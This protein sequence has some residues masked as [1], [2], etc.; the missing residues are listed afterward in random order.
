MPAPAGRYRLS[1]DTRR[2]AAI[3]RRVPLFAVEQ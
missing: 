3:I 1:N 2:R